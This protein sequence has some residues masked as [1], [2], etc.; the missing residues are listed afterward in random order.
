VTRDATSDQAQPAAPHPFASDVE[1]LDEMA[2]KVELGGDT[3]ENHAKPV[4]DSGRHGL[5]FFRSFGPAHAAYTQAEFDFD[6]DFARRYDGP[7][8]IAF[9][10][11]RRDGERF[12]SVHSGLEDVVIDLRNRGASVF[13]SWSG[14]AAD[15]A[16]TQFDTMLSAAQD[17]RSQF[18]TLSDVVAVVAGTADRATYDKAAAVGALYT[19][20]IGGVTA[21][22]VTFLVDFARRAT[23]GSVTDDDLEHAADLVGVQI[24]PAVCLANPA[25][26]PEIGS[27]V[28]S[29]LAGA[30]VP[31]YE[32]RARMFDVACSAAEETLAAAWR[33]LSEA[34]GAVRADQFDAVLPIAEGPGSAPTG[35][36]TGAAAPAAAAAGGTP[37]A[38]GGSTTSAAAVAEG[39]TNVDD[40]ASGAMSP[41]SF[42][43]GPAAPS[44]PAAPIAAAPT[45]GAA[46]PGF[47]GG[48]PFAPPAAGGGG[49]DQQRQSLHLPTTAPAFD[50]LE[51]PERAEPAAIGADDDTTH[52]N[53]AT[54]E[55]AEAAADRRN[56]PFDPV[57][58]DL[59]DDLDREPW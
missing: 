24:N 48:V 25:V 40:D 26:L 11:L 37:P 55:E 45:G 50:D 6:G 59:D 13:G 47:L 12:S 17:L 20:R 23:S 29:W 41:A 27:S 7:G 42:M 5:E 53:E 54:T 43:G 39:T 4:L 21:A 15:Q 35:T 38:A 58:G 30:F 3:G 2:A 8:D 9:G 33:H 10:A 18:G 28:D 46:G 14:G 52:Y 16:Q 31:A 32:V 36:A 34:L 44:M 19:D 49:G 1:H 56:G 57:F 51:T 22:D